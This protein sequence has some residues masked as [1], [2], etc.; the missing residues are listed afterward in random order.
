MNCLSLRPEAIRVDL[1]KYFDEGN[2]ALAME[3][4]C[5]VKGSNCPSICQELG[6]GQTTAEEAAAK[7]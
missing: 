3:F 5:S 1:Q 6:S 2:T 7:I 4:M